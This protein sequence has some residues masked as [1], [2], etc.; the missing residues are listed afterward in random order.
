MIIFIVLVLLEQSQLLLISCLFHH[1]RGDLA[2]IVPFRH[3]RKSTSDGP[4]V[5]E[6][7]KNALVQAPADT[8]KIV[9]NFTCF[10]KVTL[11]Q[12]LNSLP[13]TR[14]DLDHLGLFE[15]VATEIIVLPWCRLVDHGQRALD[16][17]I[18]VVDLVELRNE[19]LHEGLVEHHVAH[20]LVG[21]FL[22]DLSFQ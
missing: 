6:N 19:L 2:L 10:A 4:N 18:Q 5:L 13:E 20:V 21:T 17:E 16:L 11:V 9:K 1:L 15:V 14:W 3:F 8:A 22:Q 12:V 7:L